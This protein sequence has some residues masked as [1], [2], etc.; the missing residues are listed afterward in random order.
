MLILPSAASSN[1]ADLAGEIRRLGGHPYLHFDIEDGN[2]VP[3]ITFGIKTCRALRPLSEAAFD[4]HLMTTDP[5]AYI[6]ELLALD[7]KAIAFHW[8]STGY[9]MRVINAIRDGGAKAGIAVNP[10]TP[11]QE[12]IPYLPEIDYALVMTAEPDGR[13]DLFQRAM[14]DKIRALRTARPELAIVADGAVSGALLPEVKAA[15]ADAAVMGRAVF[16]APD[17]YEAI[18][19]FSRV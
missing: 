2:F 16:S 17:P 7:F 6:P 9:P 14:L 15:G 10:R 1:Q 3:N 13:G 8:E 4:A 11:A 19:A 18:C 12:I 5:M